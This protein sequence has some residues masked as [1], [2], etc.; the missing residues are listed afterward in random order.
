VYPFQRTRVSVR[1]FMGVFRYA[2]TINLP[3]R[4]LTACQ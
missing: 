4:L 2:G 3:L 1:H